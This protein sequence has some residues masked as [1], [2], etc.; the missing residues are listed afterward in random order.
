MTFSANFTA[1]DFETA[2]RRADSACQLGA[3][4]VRE[5]EIV[6]ERMWMIRPD[7]F[8]FSAD[9]IRIHGIHSAD[10]QNEPDFAA[11]WPEIE[12]YVSKD[13][14]IAHNAGFDVNVLV[15]CLQRHQLDIPDLQFNCT[16]LIA[17]QAWPSRPRYGLKPLSNWLGVE[18]KHH[19]ALE[20]SI[21]C[22]Q[23]L[24]AAG[25]AREAE[26]LEGLEKKLRIER[27]KAGEWG[28]RQAT[29]IRRRSARSRQRTDSGRPKRTPRRS[30]SRQ[31]T[32]PLNPFDE[33]A[34]A[35]NLDADRPVAA[36]AGLE[37]SLQRVLIRAEFVQ[38]LRGRC[39]VV[40]GRL[41]T[42]TEDQVI[43]VTTR[44]GGVFQSAIDETTN[45]I[46]LGSESGTGADNL[47][48]VERSVEVL[49]ES[50]FL[51]MIG[52]D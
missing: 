38:P 11:L 48:E 15:S 19:D 6:E 36:Q 31:L 3:V 37:Q 21:A 22:A 25:V 47:K 43:D 39:L 51:G 2:N 45:C 44:S 24:L 20:D 49:S 16:R 40:Q 14:L 5:G 7:P 35:R 52:L 32:L 9:N 13:C 18:F 17:K 29:K 27:G 10:V 46:V 50:E 33:Q 42:M 34:M 30:G 4:V 12:P 28:I 41:K 8:F 26:S 1:I 23:V